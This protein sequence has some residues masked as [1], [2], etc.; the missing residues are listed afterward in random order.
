MFITTFHFIE[1]TCFI[2][3]FNHSISGEQT[4][5]HLLSFKTRQVLIFRI[6][7]R[8]RLRLTLF[9]VIYAIPIAI[10]VSIMNV[11]KLVTINIRYKYFELVLHVMDY[12]QIKNHI[13]S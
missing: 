3:Y 4:N 6:V 5:K 1:P 8:V 7:T 2:Q 13:F 9:Y 12:M 11:N 10:N